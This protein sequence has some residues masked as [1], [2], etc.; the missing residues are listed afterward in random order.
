MTPPSRQWSLALGLEQPRLVRDPHVAHFAASWEGANGRASG[1]QPGMGAAFWQDPWTHTVQ[2]LPNRLEAEWWTSSTGRHGKFTHQQ[3]SPSIGTWHTMATGSPGDLRMYGY[4]CANAVLTVSGSQVANQGWIVGLYSHEAGASEYPLATLNFGGGALQV[5]VS[6]GGACSVLVGGVTLGTG[7]VGGNAPEGGAGGGWVDLV[8]Q[9]LRVRDLLIWSPTTGSGF[10][11]RL[12]H[13]LAEGADQ[14]VIPAGVFSLVHHAPTAVVQLGR[15]VYQAAGH[16]FSTPTA[17]GQAPPTFAVSF[18]RAVAA[19]PSGTSATASTRTLAG[20]AFTP[21]GVL[22]ECRVRVDMAASADGTQ[23]PFVLAAQTGFQGAT[24]LTTW[25]GMEFTPQVQGLALRVGD[26]GRATLTGS[27]WEEEWDVPDRIPATLTIGASTVLEGDFVLGSWEAG[28]APT[29]EFTLTDPRSFLDSHLFADPAVFD[30]AV[31]GQAVA[32]LAAHS[33]YPATV[34]AG[35]EFTLPLS[36]S[37]DAGDLALMAAVGDNPGEWLDRLFET[38]A[39]GWVY[40]FR[41]LSTG[42]GWDARNFAVGTP[43]VRLHNTLAAA[44]AWLAS[45]AVGYSVADARDRATDYTVARMVRRTSPGEATEV[46]VTGIE[47]LTLRPIQAFR[48]DVDAENPAANP[49]PAN[50]VGRKVRF[51]LFE[52]GLQTQ[53]AVNACVNRLFPLLTARREFYEVETGVLQ[54]PV[55]GAVIWRGD[56]VHLEGVGDCAVLSMD[57]RLEVQQSRGWHRARGIYVLERIEAGT[58]WRG[59]R[60]AGWSIDTIL[61]DRALRLERGAKHFASR[62]SSARLP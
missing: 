38:F 1:V 55:T 15:L 60:S 24:A 31:M 27:V 44:Q 3:V 34:G 22:L 37:A 45:P 6:S 40:G 53:A 18:A 4:G 57:L 48:V 46:R 8:V 29:G 36:D 49:R 33:G 7:N 51:G 26:D 54:H 47:P 58:P 43:A 17:F 56:S 35:L 21:N 30:G 19:L 2:L 50:W 12:P 14:A 59:G 61:A 9:R 28:T 41:P 52:P 42:Y 5:V 25:E 10:T 20:A 32:S 23:S 13:L 62:L 16:F 39:P 11:V